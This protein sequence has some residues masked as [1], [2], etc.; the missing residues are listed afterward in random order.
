MPRGEDPNPTTTEM[1][2]PPAASV[3]PV[4][5]VE[6]T[7]HPRVQRM[8]QRYKRRLAQELATLGAHDELDSEKL[9]K[10]YNKAM[11]KAAGGGRELT[12]E[13][14]RLLVTAAKKDPETGIVGDQ[15]ARDLLVNGHQKTASSLMG[16]YLRRKGGMSE[17]ELLQ[18]GLMGVMHAIDKYQD[19]HEANF[20][21]YARTWINKY[22]Q[23]AVGNSAET[24]KTQDFR[25]AQTKARGVSNRLERENFGITPTETQL[26]DEL[27]KN[28]G[29]DD[30]EK[31]RAHWG[32]VVRSL[33]E[34]MCSF[35]VSFYGEDSKS[36][37]DT[38]ADESVNVAAEG[39]R[40]A[41]T[42]VLA[43]H[44][45]ELDRTERE[46]VARHYGLNGYQQ[47]SVTDIAGE[48]GRNRSS[49]SAIYQRALGKMQASLVHSGF[50][51]G[52]DLLD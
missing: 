40:D 9:T 21:T 38:A 13:D 39:S 14:Q 24:Y 10:L 19:G 28:T 31:N 29:Q 26:V 48:L 51:S 33:G 32:E 11:T 37:A 20:L 5:P 18:H 30:N 15:D 43:Q 25:E 8:V 47:T 36:F 23:T 34:Q 4:D 52:D 50:E 42:Q 7:R 12:A 1:P 49:I 45:G 27:I 22:Y 2:A 44:M 6:A 3:R 35:D 46:I 17:D 41:V 16:K